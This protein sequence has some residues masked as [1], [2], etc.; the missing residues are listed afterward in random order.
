MSGRAVVWLIATLA[1]VFLTYLP[2]VQ[3]P[4]ELQ[5]DHRIIEPAL[6]GHEMNAWQT[7]LAAIRYD[8]SHIG[9]F[10]P[11]SQWFD[12]VVPFIL[13]TNPV[14]WHSLLLLIDVAVAALLFLVGWRLFRSAEAAALLAL[15]TLL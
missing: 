1:L 7:W 4:L 6:P 10:R 11:L 2:Q 5:D 13:G 9:R 15:I 8:E 14:L 3:A 12:T